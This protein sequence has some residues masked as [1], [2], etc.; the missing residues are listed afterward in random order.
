VS[1][2]RVSDANE[3]AVQ[4]MTRYQQALRKQEQ[5]LELTG[6]EQAMLE[7]EATKHLYENETW[8]REQERR[9]N[10][11]NEREG[12]LTG[13]DCKACKNRGYFNVY[14]GTSIAVAEC[15]CM[16]IRR[17]LLNLKNSGLES[18]VREKTFESFKCE[19]ELQTQMKQ[20]AKAWLEAQGFESGCASYA[21]C[22]QAQPAQASRLW[23]M[24]CGR[25][26]GVGKTHLCTAVCGVLL[27]N[28]VE[29]VYMTYR[30]DI[31]KI[32]RY[33][34][35]EQEYSRLMD[36][37]K[38]CEVLYIDDL[39]KGKTTDADISILFEL[40]D[41]RNRNDLRTI[42]STEL[43]PQELMAKDEALGGRI[44]H[45][46]GEFVVVIP[47]NAKHNY[48]ARA[49]ASGGNKERDTRQD[50]RLPYKDN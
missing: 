23:L 40:V 16:K 9:A 1:F 35:D 49:F 2:V 28:G 50:I 41:Y 36:K 20:K 14:N 11:W 33:A 13:Y 17:A 44:V 26:S 48:R 15:E 24:F 22:V 45:K 38:E 42:I 5:G 3:Q 4:E 10:E 43:S 7:Y 8:E 39:F 12:E 21:H 19:N 6:Y 46:C 29:V 27:K 31:P 30:D 25:Q 37:W 34:T 32:K 47:K 18:A